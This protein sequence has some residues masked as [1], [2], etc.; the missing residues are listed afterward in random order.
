MPRQALHLG[1]KVDVA[2]LPPSVVDAIKG[3]RADL[4]SADTTLALL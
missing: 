3:G 1:L 2:A 4:D